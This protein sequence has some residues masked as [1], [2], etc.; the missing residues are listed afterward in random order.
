[1]KDRFKLSNSFIRLAVLQMVFMFGIARMANA[2]DAKKENETQTK[3]EIF[4]SKT[5]VITKFK[6]FNLAKL[7][8][9]YASAETRIRVL[10]SGN[11]NVYFY[12]IEKEGKYNS[13]TAS[14]EYSDLLEVIK[15]LKTL[16]AEETA[17]VQSNPDYLENKF[18]TS[19]GFQVG[20]YVSNG[21]STW[22]VRLEKYGSDNTLFFNSVDNIEQSMENASN[23]INELKN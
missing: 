1:M 17:D 10:T 14:I 15:A 3:M 6:D 11:N 4:S 8:A 9:M 21:K 18:T 23:K 2:Q 13:T 7:P 22:Y 20:Y 19:D 12:Q 16:K 5:G